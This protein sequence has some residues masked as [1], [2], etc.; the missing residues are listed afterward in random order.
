MSNFEFQQTEK[1]FEVALERMQGMMEDFAAYQ[2]TLE[3]QDKFLDRR[4]RRLWSLRTSLSQMQQNLKEMQQVL[5]TELKK[6]QASLE[7][8]KRKD[9]KNWDEYMQY[10]RWL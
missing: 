5:D 7:Q 9:K 6:N 4:E 2:G 10:G 1:R 8:D 3:Q